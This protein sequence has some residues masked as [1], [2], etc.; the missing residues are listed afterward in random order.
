MFFLWIILTV[1][2]K[3]YYNKTG[4]DIYRTL[5]K[6]FLTLV[7]IDSVVIVFMAIIQASMF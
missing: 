4:E 1:V 6:I 3:K 5:Y 7:V 2:F